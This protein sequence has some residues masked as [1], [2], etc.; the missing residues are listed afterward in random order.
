MLYTESHFRVSSLTKY[1]LSSGY[2]SVNIEY[3]IQRVLGSM[4]PIVTN[5]NYSEKV[6]RASLVFNYLPDPTNFGRKMYW[7]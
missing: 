5:T 1:L 3:R 4:P 2:L 6:G 7:I